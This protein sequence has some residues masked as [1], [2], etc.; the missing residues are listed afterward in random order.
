MMFDQ[1]L[2]NYLWGEAI[3]TAMYIQ[4]RCPHVNLKDKTLEEVFSGIKP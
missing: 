4:N 1:D 3:S 2:P